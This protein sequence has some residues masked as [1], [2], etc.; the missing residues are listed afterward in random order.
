MRIIV[1]AIAAAAVPSMLAAQDTVLA[2]SREPLPVRTFALRHL[3][4]EQAGRLLTPYVY[5][6]NAAVFPGATSHEIT[7]RASRRTL[8]I[9]DS[10]LREHDLPRATVTLKFQ[11]YA[12]VDS[13]GEQLPQ[14][15]GPALRST[16][17]FN[18][19]RLL[20]QGSISTS[21]DAQFSTTLGAAGMQGDATLYRVSGA[22]E[23]I[24]GKANGSIP[25]A[26]R[27][28]E[29]SPAGTPGP[30]VFSTGLAVPL[31]QT[32]VLGSGAVGAYVPVKGEPRPERRTQALI[33][34][35]HPEV[36]SAKPD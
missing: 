11:L 36:V 27:L 23:S 6:P 28:N 34:A 3:D 19:Y 9:V 13:G 33:L 24:G 4:R 12:A 18:G 25:L 32:V 5:E 29:V 15:L 22:V 8:Q 30:E 26:I 1:F 2:R 14:D 16:F 7:V 20:S 17:R 31:G 21:E 35:V 10:L